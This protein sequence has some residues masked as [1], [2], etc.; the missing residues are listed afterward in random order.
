MKPRVEASQ[1]KPT[2]LQG[3]RVPH[4]S[5]TTLASPGAG[6][7]ATAGVTGTCER[8]FGD[9]LAA[10]PTLAGHG[11]RPDGALRGCGPLSPRGSR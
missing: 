1:A 11:A 9:P 7:R 10:A 4:G 3:N 8:Q 6:P 2:A 5:P